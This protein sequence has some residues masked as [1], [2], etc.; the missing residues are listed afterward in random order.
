MASAS[1]ASTTSIDQATSF[2]QLCDMADLEAPPDDAAALDLIKSSGIVI[3]S[4]CDLAKKAKQVKTARLER[5]CCVLWLRSLIDEPECYLELSEPL[6]TYV[7]GIYPLRAKLIPIVGLDRACGG[8]SAVL[9]GFCGQTCGR[10]TPYGRSQRRQVRVRID[11]ARRSATT[12][13]PPIGMDGNRRLGW[14]SGREAEAA[15]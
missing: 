2:Q 8:K 6:A 12:R 5:A 13:T 9:G 11:Q 3:P 7:Q 1:T 15:E 10:W 14:N 4:D